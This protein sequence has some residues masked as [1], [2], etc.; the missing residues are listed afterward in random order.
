MTVADDGLNEAVGGAAEAEA[1]GLLVQA[2]VRAKWSSPSDPDAVEAAGNALP[3][4]LRR[5]VDMLGLDD[6]PL[7]HIAPGSV[8]Q[9]IASID[10]EADLADRNAISGATHQSQRTTRQNPR[11]SS[12]AARQSRRR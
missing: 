1:C 12:G 11:Q 7:L 2:Y 3:G 4:D 5:H 8:L 10:A 6:R 9:R